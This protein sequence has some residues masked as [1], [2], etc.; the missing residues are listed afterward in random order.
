MD[1]I[2]LDEFESYGVR[3]RFKSPIEVE[4]KSDDIYWTAEI[5]ALHVFAVGDTLD[6]LEIDLHAEICDQWRGLASE[7]DEALTIRAVKLKHRMLDAI[8]EIKDGNDE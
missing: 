5:D 8:E 6:A 4:V 7:P 1:K 2:T 3:L